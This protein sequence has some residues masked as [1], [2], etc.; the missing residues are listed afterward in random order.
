MAFG[1]YGPVHA[2][3]SLII[4]YSFCSHSAPYSADGKKPHSVTAIVMLA[5]QRDDTLR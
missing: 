3:I 5:G 1:A 2:I 4:R